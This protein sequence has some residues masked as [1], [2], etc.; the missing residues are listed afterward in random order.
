MSCHLSLRRDCTAKGRARNSP[1]CPPENFAAPGTNCLRP[2]RG[3][4][5]AVLNPAVVQEAW[6]RLLPPFSGDG[7][8]DL[9]PLTWAGRDVIAAMAAG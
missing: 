2:A 3:G 8:S 9:A 1:V 5:A 7:V 4:T 6:Y